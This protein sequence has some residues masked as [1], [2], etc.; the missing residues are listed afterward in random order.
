MEEK[1]MKE[2]VE[3][4]QQEL[5]DTK[6]KLESKDSKIAEADKTIGKLEEERKVFKEKLEELE[7]KLDV[8]KDEKETM[9]EKFVKLSDAFNKFKAETIVKQKVPIINQI[10]EFEDS[11][12]KDDLKE[13]YLGW[14]VEKLEK[15]LD[16]KKSEEQE[17]KIIVK[18]LEDERK[19]AFEKFRGKIKDVGMGALQSL[20]KEDLD[21][22]A[23]IEAEM[24]AEGIL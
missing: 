11:S 14:D 12:M 3:K 2:L 23:E 7:S 1:E 8:S 21:I 15:R 13:L 22:A 20:R 10:L 5:N 24:K 17:A 4:L 16:E 18:T 19:E 9:E 6:M